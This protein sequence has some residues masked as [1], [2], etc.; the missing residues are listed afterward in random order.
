MVEPTS[1]IEEFK[2]P[3]TEPVHGLASVPGVLGVPRW[4]PTGARVCVVLAH[5]ANSDYTDPL[6][7]YLQRE[8]TERRYLTLR[9]NFPFAEA[10]KTRPDPLPVLRRTFRSALGA[11]ARDPTAAPAHLVLC[12]MGLGAQAAADVAGARARVDALVLLGFPLHPQ[13]KPEKVQPETLFRIVSP[14]LFLQGTRDRRCDLDVLRRT[15]TRVGAPTALHAIQH[16]DHHFA[17]PKKSGRTPEDVREEIL[18][19]IDG[20][21]QKVL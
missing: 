3:L 5:G 14:M 16:A 8:L 10:K 4:W 17:V 2:I 18:G 9:F 11:I 1:R 20:W 15:L 21:I 6:I 7:E 13:G 12:G 19:A